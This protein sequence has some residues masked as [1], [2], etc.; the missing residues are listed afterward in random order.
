MEN[1]VADNGEEWE[2]IMGKD[3][4][5]RRLRNG[6]GNTAE[7]GTVVRCDLRGYFV[8]DGTPAEKPFEEWKAQSFKVGEND[9]IPGI[10]MAVR[11]SRVGDLTRVRFKSK[12]G[13]GY[14]GRPPV[15]VN[16]SGENGKQSDGAGEA[17]KSTIIAIPPD[18]DLEYEIAV[19]A[20]LAD[21]QTDPALLEKH[22][23]APE[24]GST[25]ER[26]ADRM[27]ALT[28]LTQ[29]KEAG[30]RWFSYG[31][32]SRAARAY[33]KAT[34]VADRYFNGNANVGDSN[35]KAL[36]GLTTPAEG[37]SNADAVREAEERLAAAERE[38][39]AQR[40]RYEQGDEEVVGVYVSCLNN[41]AAAQLRLGENAKAKDICVR[42][43]EMDPGNHKALL[44][45]AK[46][47]LATHVRDRSKVFTACLFPVLI[48]HHFLR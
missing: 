33:S 40:R 28:E 39:E 22:P 1:S 31:D 24:G 6:E 48:A 35:A 25:P 36:Q 47:A 41:M 32:F 42:V 43:L 7:M 23:F 16:E 8:V 15:Q 34:Q 46:A 14:V 3:L 9:A 2:E 19:S 13:Y 37:A 4:I 38:K 29:R 21:G 5:F 10:E 12:F 11:F 30:N 20:H 18:M 17:E 26:Y 45:A 27:L 44:R